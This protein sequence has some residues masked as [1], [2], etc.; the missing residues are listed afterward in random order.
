MLAYQ[1]S[2]E[3]ILSFIPNLLFE[4][5]IHGYFNICIFLRPPGLVFKEVSRRS[6][7]Q[8]NFHIVRFSG[9][10]WF[11]NVTVGPDLGRSIYIDHNQSVNTQHHPQDPWTPVP[12]SLTTPE[13]YS[14]S[15]FPTSIYDNLDLIPRYK[16][17][18]L[19]RMPAFENQIP[20]LSYRFCIY[21]NTYKLSSR[22]IPRPIL[23]IKALLSNASR[24][25]LRVCFDQESTPMIPL[26]SAACSA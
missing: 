9:Y 11:K 20:S 12:S 17:I 24:A 5:N 23:R 7:S 22:P 3:S 25:R 19:G 26:T 13:R 16:I 4:L 14:Y 6:R 2:V 1:T 21:K 10:S 8:L 18:S 15:R